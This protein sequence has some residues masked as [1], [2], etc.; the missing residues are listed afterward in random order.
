MQLSLHPTQVASSACQLDNLVTDPT[1]VSASGP[2]P[3]VAGLWSSSRPAKLPVTVQHARLPPPA[4][5]PLQ[6]PG[7]LNI[8]GQ[9]HAA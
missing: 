8:M 3:L 4:L 2:C 7:Y 1:S 9:V 6:D 5:D